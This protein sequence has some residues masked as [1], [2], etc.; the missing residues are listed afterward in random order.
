MS[1]YQL[2]NMCP[3]T[4]AQVGGGGGVGF[5]VQAYVWTHGPC[6]KQ[7]CK[8]WRYKKAEDGKMYEGC[9]FEYMGLNIETIKENKEM[10]TK[11]IDET[12]KASAGAGSMVCLKCMKRYDSTWK[13]CIKCGSQLVKKEE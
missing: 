5:D 3:F 6:M 11:L 1:D 13:V 7:Y 4:M 8:L 12:I 9:V 2:F 10:Q